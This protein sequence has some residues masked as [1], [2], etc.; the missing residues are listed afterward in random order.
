[1]SQTLNYDDNIVAY[2][3]SSKNS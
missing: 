3:N 2:R 1:M